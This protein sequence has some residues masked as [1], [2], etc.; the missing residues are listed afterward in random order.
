MLRNLTAIALF[1]LAGAALACDDARGGKSASASYA[2]DD[3]VPEKTVA[4]P[5]KPAVKEVATPVS[6]EAS[7]TKQSAPKKRAPQGK[8]LA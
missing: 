2:P 8:P 5:A 4:E 1:V 7:K 3:G 6:T